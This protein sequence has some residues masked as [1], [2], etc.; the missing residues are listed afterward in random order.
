M[1]RSQ[2]HFAMKAH[3]A[4]DTIPWMKHTV[5]ARPFTLNGI[6]QANHL[7]YPEKST[8]CLDTAYSGIDQLPKSK[9]LQVTW[10]TILILGKRKRLYRRNAIQVLI[11]RVKQTKAN[12][13]AKIEHHF[14]SVE[15]LCGYTKVRYCGLVKNTAQMSTFFALSN[16]Y[17]VNT[18]PGMNM[19]IAPPSQTEL[20]V[21]SNF[22]K[23]SS[24]FMNFE[25]Q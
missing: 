21:L 7:L 18:E 4:D 14:P 19:S 8:I 25:R 10:K 3:I 20:G 15:L 13:N 5:I 9:G 17:M 16:L 12:I 22:G 6:T 2:W 11:H 23:K 24:L 1:K